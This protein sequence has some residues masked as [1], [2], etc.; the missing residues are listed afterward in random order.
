[1]ASQKSSA[2]AYNVLLMSKALVCMHQQAYA[3]NQQ[4][5]INRSDRPQIE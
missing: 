4:E 1:M 5:E 3:D 2:N